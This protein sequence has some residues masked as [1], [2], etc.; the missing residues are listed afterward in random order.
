[1]GAGVLNM[2][3]DEPDFDE[4]TLGRDPELFI[5]KLQLCLDEVFRPCR[6]FLSSNLFCKCS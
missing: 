2:G 5:F 6:C 1:M 4:L 3:I